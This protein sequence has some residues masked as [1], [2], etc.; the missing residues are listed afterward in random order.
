MDHY[1]FQK[2][3]SKDTKTEM[4]SDT[5]EFSDHKLTLISVTLEDKVLH[6]VQQLTESI[7]N[8]P[9]STVDA[10]LQAIK[11][12]QDTIEHWAGDTK[13]PISTAGLLR[14]IL[15]TKRHRDPKVTI[16][17]P[18]TLPAPRVNASPLQGCNPFQQRTSQPIVIKFPNVCVPNWG[19][20][21][22]NLQQLQNNR[23]PIVIDTKPPNKL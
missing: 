19:Q 2:V 7:K 11:A 9:A 1:R 18:E 23:W 15:S 4:V 3:V 17:K 5:I 6:G 10:Q 20:S 21:N 14:H 13:A 8:T 22:W 16:A 12:L